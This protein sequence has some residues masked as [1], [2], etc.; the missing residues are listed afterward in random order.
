MTSPRS[1]GESAVEDSDPL[2]GTDTARR[3]TALLAHPGAAWT[4]PGRRSSPPRFLSSGGHHESSAT[5]VLTKVPA[6]G[7]GSPVPITDAAMTKD[8]AARRVAAGMVKE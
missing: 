4:M 7:D 1:A 6:A 2:T 5:L 8:P 3:S